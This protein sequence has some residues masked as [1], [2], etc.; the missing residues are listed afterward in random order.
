M[1]II[2]CLPVVDSPEHKVRSKTI[3]IRRGTIVGRSADFSKRGFNG[4]VPN[5]NARTLYGTSC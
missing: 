2:D 3:A 1:A 4:N 5:S